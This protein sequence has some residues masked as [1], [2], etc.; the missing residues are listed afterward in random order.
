MSANNGDKA[1]HHSL[2]KRKLARRLLARDLK[3]A[4]S[5]TAAK[6]A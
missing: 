1:R 3:K 2:R 5:E 4:A 6:K